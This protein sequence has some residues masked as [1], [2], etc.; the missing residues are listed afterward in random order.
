MGEME[1]KAEFYYEKLKSNVEPSVV[2]REF[3]TEITGMP[4]GRTEIIM[5]NKFLK[6]FGRFTL[7]FAIMD[8]AN[9]RELTG[10]LHG[11]LYA[12]CKSRFEKTHGASNVQA[13]VSLDK[14]ISNLQKQKEKILSGK[15]SDIPSAEGLE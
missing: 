15:K 7:F 11:L 5:I 6:I 4:V 9:V 8:L 13:F 1:N 10:S 12:I 14:Q 3:F 2:L